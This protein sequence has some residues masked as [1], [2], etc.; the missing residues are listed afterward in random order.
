MEME[1]EETGE[2]FEI[3]VGNGKTVFFA[4]RRNETMRDFRQRLLES[5]GITVNLAGKD[6]D[7][8]TDVLSFFSTP[9]TLGRY[10]NI[11]RIIIHCA[12]SWQHYTIVLGA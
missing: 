11:A 7:E 1:D 10:K 8:D 9:V 12:D 2:Y 3:D 4:V 5:T 6:F